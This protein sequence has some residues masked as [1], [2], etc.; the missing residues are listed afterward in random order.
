MLAY[1]PATREH[2][3]KVGYLGPR[4]TFTDQAAR[5]F[6]MDKHVSSMPE[7]R[8][9]PYRTIPD[10]LSDVERGELD[11]GVVPIENSTEGSVSVTLDALVHEVD[12]QIVGETVL[13]IRH[14]L[15]ARPGIALEEIQAVISHPQ[16]LAQCRKNIEKL[17]PDVPLTA[18]TSTAE[19]AEQIATSPTPLAAIGTELA[20]KLYGLE[21]L[22]SDMQDFDGNETRF[23]KVS[24]ERGQR[25]GQDKTSIVFAF[26]TDKPGNLYR[27]LKAFADRNVNLTKLE[28][29]PAKRNLGDY[30]FFVDMEGYVTD[31]VVSDA[32]ST[33]Q[34]QCAFFKVL[35]SYP[36][37]QHPHMNGNGI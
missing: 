2:N 13:P 27:A 8:L 5:V 24:K 34:S 35:G 16:A 10:V 32:L 22:R 28:S 9:I 6:F 20:A 25:T 18:A 23:I 36:R 19:A 1:N 29:R 15:M 26:R 14:H 30:I 7:P 11:Y 37:V 3:V 31:P 17:L 12:V 33:I 4:G 21:I